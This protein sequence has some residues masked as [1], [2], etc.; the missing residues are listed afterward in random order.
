MYKVRYGNDIPISWSITRNDE[1]E[2]FSRVRSLRLC[3]IGTRE[4]REVTDY[5]I[6]GNVLRWVFYGKDQKGPCTYRFTLI[7]NEG[8]R[9]MYTIDACDALRLTPTTCA[10]DDCDGPFVLC[11]HSNLNDKGAV[12]SSVI[13]IPANGLSAYEIALRNGFRGTEQEWLDYLA[14]GI[15]YVPVVLSGDYVIPANPKPQFE[16]VYYISI[17]HDVHT[18][19]ADE[20]VMWLNGS[21]PKCE[22]DTTMVVS[23]INNMAVWGTFK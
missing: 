15:Q 18:V 21:P 19:S 13:K 20:G 5:I 10:A 1:P 3:M 9:N 17:G 8:E 4:V 14:S 7:E 22:P 2:D 16:I 6:D 11:I 23:I 12:C